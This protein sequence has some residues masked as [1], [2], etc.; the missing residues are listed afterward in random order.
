MTGFPVSIT[1]DLIARGIISQHGVF[2]PEEI[3]PTDPFL[4]ELPRRDIHIEKTE[5]IES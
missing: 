3:I 1:A 5:K 2:C 4:Q